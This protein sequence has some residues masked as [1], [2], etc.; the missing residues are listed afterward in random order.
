MLKNLFALQQ[1]SAVILEMCI[2][3]LDFKLAKKPDSMVIQFW[4]FTTR[5]V[6]SDNTSLGNLKFL[7]Q[8]YAGYGDLKKEY[9]VIDFLKIVQEYVML[10]FFSS[11][12]DFKQ[13]INYIH[14][15]YLIEIKIE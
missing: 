14:Q 8:K 9:M 3:V 6:T 13:L 5:A 12:D 1:S 10:N 2:S 11:Q 4:L 7:F 15:K